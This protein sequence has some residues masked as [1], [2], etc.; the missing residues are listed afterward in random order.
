MKK[1]ISL[2]ALDMDGTL[3]DG[4]SR[5]SLENQ[6]AILSAHNAGIEIAVSTGRP[7]AGLPTELLS[8]I[9]IRFAITSNG[10]AIYRLADKKCLAQDCM[11]PE[12]VCPILRKIQKK[13]LHMD[14]FIDGGC[15]SQLSCKPLIDRLA[16][17]ESVRTYIKETR[18]FVED[19]A[20]FI[21]AQK[22]AVQKMTLQFLPLPDGTMQERE[23]VKDILIKC[24]DITFLSGGF[25]NLEFTK[26][27]VTKGMGLKH[28]CT[29]L[30]IPL[31]ETL[32]C[33]D[34]ENDLDILKTAAVGVAMANADDCVREAADFITLS[35]E[36]SGVAFAIRHFTG[37]I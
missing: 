5:I 32:A 37:L 10:A 27:G 13:E 17:P 12:L 24:P 9:G 30:D 4:S 3:F 18:T 22:L 33:G 28:L 2:I 6:H 7:Y 35:N 1:K 11:P 8:D 14:A 26:K 16:V 31:E 19:L 15:F 34:S 21:S 29:L 36:E 25:R 23:A 20:A